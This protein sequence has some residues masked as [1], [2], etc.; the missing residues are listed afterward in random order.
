MHRVVSAI[1]LAALVPLC[2]MA[3][4]KPQASGTFS[5]TKYKFE[6]IGAYAYWSRSSEEPL[7]EVAVSNDGFVPAAFDAFYDPKPV[8]ENE[9]VDQRTAVIYFQFEPSGRYHGMTYYIGSGD[10]CGYCSDGSAKSTV[11]VSG[12]RAKGTLKYKGENRSYDIAFD[13]PIAPKEWGPAIKGDGGDI[14]A[15]YKTYNKAMES[16]DR[17][18]IFDA[19]DSHL[20]SF[21][22]KQEK[23]GKL[24]GYLEYRQQS[25]HYHISEAHIIRGFSRPDEAVLLV[26]A[27]SPLLDH[28]HG[29]VVLKREGGRWKISDEVYETGE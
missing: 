26:N 22:K 11:S 25:V 17:Q 20:Q 5:G 15:A 9:F 6:V 7:I 13:V 24:D 18:A 8:I 3:A 4:D 12:G 1:A 19:L 21:W 16:G 29:Q 28:L 14:G 27:S 10:G 2:L 23:A